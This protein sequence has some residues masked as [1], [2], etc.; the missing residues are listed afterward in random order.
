MLNLATEC[1]HWPPFPSEIILTIGKSRTVERFLRAASKRSFQV[2]VAERAPW[3]DGHEMAARLASV[4]IDTTVITDSAIFAMMARVNKVIIG[5][6][7]GSAATTHYVT[8]NGVGRSDRNV[9]E[10]M[11]GRWAQSWRTAACWRRRAP[12][13]SRWPRS[14][15]RRPSSCSPVR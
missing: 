11:A 13:W 2:I 15:T 14:T 12:T 1:F 10:T 4:P 7:A 8:G 6:H 5:T 9:G 3:Y